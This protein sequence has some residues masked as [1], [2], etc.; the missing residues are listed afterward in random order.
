M[1]LPRLPPP[2]AHHFRAS[3][4]AHEADIMSA[5]IAV[6][7]PTVGRSGPE[8]ISRGWCRTVLH[9]CFH[10]TPPPKSSVSTARER[11]GDGRQV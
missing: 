4:Q 10:A 3:N 1:P 9:L 8:K 5:A 2:A 11:W 6:L 7:P